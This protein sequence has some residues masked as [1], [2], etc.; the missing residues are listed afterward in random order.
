[1]GFAF[2]EFVV[3]IGLLSVLASAT[4]AVNAGQASDDANA[5]KDPCAAIGG[6]TWVAP[7]DVRAC[8][9]SVKVDP[10]IKS[11]IIEVVNKTLAFHISTNYQIKAPAPF[12]Y[13]VHEDLMADVAKISHTNYA[14]EYDFHIA[15]SRAVARLDDAMFMNY[16]PL[17]LNL[18]VD[19]QGKQDV[20]IAKEAFSIA[21]AEFGDQIS[22][23]QNALPGK[24][25]GQL[26]SLSGA[27]IIA[28]NGRP[29]FDSVNANAAIS[30]SYE[31]L[32]TRQS[33]YFSSYRRTPRGWNYVLGKFAEQGLPLDDQVTLTILRTNQTR[34]DVVTIPYRSKL[35]LNSVPFN[36]T[37]SWRDGNCVALPDT[38]G[39]DYYAPPLSKDP[40]SV[41]P[42]QKFQQQPHLTPSKQQH[43]LDVILDNSPPTDFALPQ[44]L[45]PSLPLLDG[46]WGVTQFYMLEDGKTGVMVLGSFEDGEYESFLDNMLEGLTN[47]KQ[48][49]A[50]R[51]IVD[52]TN[53][54]GGWTCAAAY[55]H[56]IIS[57][58]KSTVEPQAI[59]DTKTR[60][61]PLAKL[62]VKAAISGI[63][64]DHAMMYNPHGR[65][66]ANNT[67]FAAD[68]DWLKNTVDLTING[69]KDSFSQRLGRECTSYDYPTQPPDEALFDGKQVAIVSNGRCASS[70]ALFQ[71]VMAK[72]EGSKTVVVGGK[73]DI[74]QQYCGTVGGQSTDFSG[75]DSEIKVCLFFARYTS[76]LVNGVL[77]VTWR[78]AFGVEN[79][80][81][82]EE[83]QSHP[84][85]LNLLLTPQLVNNP[86]AIWK[87]VASRVFN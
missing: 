46:S 67:P 76:L 86:V 52:M 5:H 23:W 38:N 79:T 85:D 83:W 19:S 21:S 49:N 80:Q 33:A 48:Q 20:Y 29:P 82:P 47:L 2:R 81:E 42:V 26:A 24:L 73:Q 10:K 12:Q 78:L 57:G 8:Y 66:N 1:M 11:N 71:V 63:D 75:I 41:S 44:E 58:P 36:D 37:S 62:L 77:G 4:P 18:L 27:K 61:G 70:C 72:R 13:D 31:G 40:S 55:L 64:P 84:A 7:K 43:H 9:K 3:L 39:R 51:L 54:G 14:S 28:I 30:G 25:K 60:A 69:R 17:P 32:G 53:N 35:G 65:T 22:F 74:T 87:E 15:L 59:L 56:R 50:T 16:V 34:P 6:K 68:E 45:T